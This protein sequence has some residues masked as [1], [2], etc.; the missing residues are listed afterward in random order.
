M[1]GGR[2]STSRDGRRYWPRVRRPNPAR[3]KR[4]QPQ[5][6]ATGGE[7]ARSA[8]RVL[9]PGAFTL[10]DL[11]DVILTA[12]GWVGGHLHTFDV[13]GRD[14]GDPGVVHDVANENRITLQTGIIKA[15][16]KRFTYTYDFGDNWD[17]V[18][19]DRENRIRRG[20]AAILSASKESATARRKIAAAPGDRPNSWRSSPTP[21]TRIAPSAWSGWTTKTSTP[22]RSD[23]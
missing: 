3:Q 9:V 4:R 5:G 7:A 13:A 14:Y 23:L 12:M 11:S 6:D 21:P 19:F 10:R 17:H 15:G 1:A 22:R 20:R 8:C 18:Y 16:V 2:S